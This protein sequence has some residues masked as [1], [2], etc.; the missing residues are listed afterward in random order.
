MSRNF[1]I[2]GLICLCGWG[3]GTANPTTTTTPQGGQPAANSATKKYRIAVIPKG[4]THE[5]WKSVHAGAERA[6]KELGNVEVVWK[7]PLLEN[8]REGQIS[9]VQ[10]FVVGKL[11]GI[12]LAP[13]DSQALVPSVK[14]AQAAGI[15]VLIFYSGLD[16][17]DSYVSYVATDNYH[18]GVL[19]AEHLGKLLEGQGGV[20]MMRYAVGSESTEQREQGFLET[21]K[22]KF[23]NIEILSD[24]QY[25]G[26][27]PE[28]SLDKS[29]QLLAQ[30]GDKVTGI[31]TVCEP[32]TTGMLGAL[33][34]KGLAGKVKFIGFDPSP[35]FL[36]AMR[37]KKIH[38]IVLQDPIAMGYQGVKA[39]MQHISGQSV[40][41]RVPTGEYLAT[42]EN[43]DEEAMKKLLAPEQ[44]GE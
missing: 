10:N 33:E 31:F 24:N 13:L 14:E 5:F 23:P 32:N 42:P 26:T 44:F 2:L 30:F 15:P 12:V 29:Q 4:T 35:R 8:D 37:N 7:G 34:D 17:A 1:A 6:A 43:M 39:I 36:E 38:G 21:L 11:D 40:E 41:K 28:T 20:I 16:D 25:S 27:T 9:I 18:G 19:A 22:E 3:C